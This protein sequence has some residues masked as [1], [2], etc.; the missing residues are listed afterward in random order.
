MASIVAIDKYLATGHE[1]GSS[2]LG[3]L[4]HNWN[5]QILTMTK[6]IIKF[7]QKVG[8]ILSLFLLILTLT[9]CSIN[10]DIVTNSDIIYKYRTIHNSEGIGK[11]YRQVINLATTP[12]KR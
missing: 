3:K 1:K 11:F 8:K 6:N 12:D 2:N 10:T 7:L 9:S 4:A 5:N